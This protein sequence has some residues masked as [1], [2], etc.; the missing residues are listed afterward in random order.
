MLTKNNWIT[1]NLDKRLDGSILDL[2]VKLNP[3]RFQSIDFASASRIVAE[4]IADLFSTIYVSMSG[5][6]DSEY[7]VR[8][9]HRLGIPFTA[10]AVACGNKIEITHAYA[11][12]KELD[13]TPVILEV[14]VEDHRKYYYENIYK[15]FN[16][17]GWHSTQL[18]MATEYVYQRDALIISG[19]HLIGDGSDIINGVRYAS[20]SEWDYYHHYS[21]SN[22]KIIDFLL[23]TPQIAYALLPSDIEPIYWNVY[24]EKLYGVRYRNKVRPYYSA[25]IKKWYHELT[26]PIKDSIV[27]QCYWSKEQ[28]DQIFMPVLE[29]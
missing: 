5:G 7:I 16:G 18:L 19:N 20:V 25:E 24:K 13:I 27:R 17:T 12:F 28:I 2:E 6:M 1:T 15:K 9:L 29:L 22:A 11:L 8:L 26:D 21:F 4:E 23:Y 3:Y 10:I 14:D